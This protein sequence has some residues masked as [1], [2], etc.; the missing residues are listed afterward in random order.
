[1]KW[2][3]NIATRLLTRTW[4]VSALSERRCLARIK[5]RE[6]SGRRGVHR[7]STATEVNAPSVAVLIIPP[8]QTSY[9]RVADL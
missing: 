2:L 1:M 4:L 5:V 6:T 3:A 7:S 8:L 9:A